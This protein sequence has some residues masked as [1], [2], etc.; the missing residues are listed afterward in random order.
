MKTIVYLAILG[1]LAWVST[2]APCA[3]ATNVQVFKVF[4]KTEAE[5]YVQAYMRQDYNTCLNM[6]GGALVNALGGKITVLDHY[7]RT[8]EALQQHQMKLETMTVDEPR[9]V[10]AR[11]PKDQFVVIP[12]K[13]I[14]TGKE[15]K[16]ILNSYLLAVSENNGQSWNML[17]GSWRVS[18]HIKNYDLV[19]YNMLKLPERKI[20]LADDP[21]IVMLEK[22]GG[23]V[24]PPETLEYR[25]SLRK[26]N[27]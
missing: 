24:T 3:A 18:E 16:Y 14:F 2:P 26:G 1:M 22:G 25:K 6:M 10:V 11:G 15:G 12:E 17:E 9:P 23:F 7:R 4:M 27:L 19:L 20:Y 8:A 5:K 21:N 13:H